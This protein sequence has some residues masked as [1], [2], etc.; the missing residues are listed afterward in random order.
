MKYTFL[1][2]A[3]ISTATFSQS[4]EV[5]SLNNY[6]QCASQSASEINSVIKSLQYYY[7]TFYRTEYVVP[8]FTCPVQMDEQVYAVALK[9]SNSLLNEKLKRL[10]SDITSIH[11][12]CQK[13]ET[14]HKLKDFE[15]DNLAKADE[16]INE[17][18]LLVKS[19][20][21][22][23]ADLN[24]ALSS[25]YSKLNASNTPDRKADELMRQAIANEGSF[26]DKWSLNLNEKVA[27]GW[28]FDALKESIARTE[29]SL[30]QLQ[31]NPAASAPYTSFQEG[32]ADVLA[33]K[34][35]AL[36]NYNPSARTSDKFSNDLYS[37]L[38]NNING[39]LVKDYNDFIAQ[40]KYTG[41]FA[42]RYSPVFEVRNT[43]SA[44]DLAIKPFNDAPHVPITIAK[45][46]TALTKNAFQSLNKYVDFINETLGPIEILCKKTENFSSTAADYK[47]L[48]S[49]ARR[50]QLNYEVS[51]FK[52]PLTEYTQTIAASNSLPASISRSLNTQATVLLDILKEL[53]QLII[54]MGNETSTKNYEND[55]LDKIYVVL[56]RHKELLLIWDERKEQMYN[57]VRMVYDAY[58]PAV[59]TDSWYKSGHALQLLVD[60]NHTALFEAKALYKINDVSKG[61][62]TIK[63]DSLRRAV[64]ENE[65]T[66]LKG[67]Q[68]LGGSNGNDPFTPY[69]KVAQISEPLSERFAALKPASQRPPGFNHPYN[70]QVHL[71]N[72]SAGNL[73][74]FSD[75]SKTAF[76]LHM[77]QQP[78][79][80]K[81]NYPEKKTP[82]E[83]LPQPVVSE[84]PE[85]IGVPDP[86]DPD[87]RNMDGYANNNLVLVID[88]SGSMNTPDKLPLLKQSLLGLLP[89][90]RPEDKVAIVA[91][92]E[93]ARVL[94]QPTSFKDEIKLTNAIARLTSSGK[95]NSYAGLK[96]AYKVADDNYLRAGNN[97]IILATDGEF[98][99]DEE[100]KKFIADYAKQDIS[101]TVFNFGA[102]DKTRDNLEQLSILGGGNFADIKKES[103]EVDLIR[104]VK[105]KKSN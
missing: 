43:A 62:S 42:P 86:P 56:E 20:H 26:I 60:A 10:Q 102:R 21:K 103:A 81:I 82:P 69:E 32:L 8:R 67:I 27:S 5:A 93:K 51:N 17:L 80:F 39:A 94:L 31:A 48:K 64:V 22:K 3:F 89:M 49:F 59:P 46:K 88:V 13:L 84:V 30:K 23:Q 47:E 28:P 63:I 53:E 72:I 96:M 65:F 45:Q 99:V 74:K 97:R 40:A 38:V 75:L 14:Y 90:M 71:Y 34:Q 58:P 1:L 76:I 54:I 85:N 7:L 98:P 100:M 101:L 78:P 77:V 66:N 73:N 91:Y 19:Y 104:E 9:G 87:L 33:I 24:T 68:R 52:I 16:L 92:S 41:L 57:D 61:I 79:L 4:A 25:A 83:P 36:N 55:H 12:A 95:T 44:V 105:A 37:E 6:T 35:H 11:L 18:Q 70:E 50:D 15:R 29:A 2:F